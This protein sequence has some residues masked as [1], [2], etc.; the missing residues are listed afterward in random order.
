M[1][2]SEFIEPLFVTIK[3]AVFTSGI[4]LVV[5]LPIAN[6]LAFSRSRFLPLLEALISM[7]MVLPPSVLGYYFL[8]AYSPQNWFG[9]WLNDSLNIRL[10]FSFE[11]ILIAS[12]VFGLPFMIQ[13]IQNGLR[14]L[15][16]SLRE[17]SYTLGKSKKETFFRVLL[18]NISTS[19]VTA[20]ALTFAHCI[21]EFGVVLIVGGDMPGVTRVAS[22]A[23]Y[24][25]AQALNF[26]TANKYAFILFLSSFSMLALIYALNKKTSLWKIQ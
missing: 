13:P 7:P 22:I 23:I 21:G 1:A 5:A 9:K 8:I 4:L 2:Y 16:P 15:P 26:D 18:P 6:Y 10:A 3:L 20:I 25:E 19:I 17:V 24:D 12:V 14:A 11:G